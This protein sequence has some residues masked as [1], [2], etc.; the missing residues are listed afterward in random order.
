MQNVLF[1][2]A[3]AQELAS[4]IQPYIYICILNYKINLKVPKKIND[5][6]QLAIIE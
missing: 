2:T 5:I 6:N 3:K 1:Q 4:L